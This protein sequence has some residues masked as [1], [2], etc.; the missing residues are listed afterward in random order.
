MKH[1]VEEFLPSLPK[2]ANLLE[3]G[4]GHGLLLHLANSVPN[5]GPTTAWDVSDASLELAAHTLKTFGSKKVVKFQKRNIFEPEI[6]APENA[7]L[8]DGVVLSE[9]L[10]HL[11]E[12]LRAIQVLF[13]ICKPG[14]KVWINVPA[15]SPAPDHLYLVN[16]LADAVAVVKE[17]GFEIAAEVAY[18]MSG[19]TL[20]RAKK[21]KLTV[22]CI[23]VGRKPA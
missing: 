12:P 2:G 7:G 8:F 23:V 9:V 1:Y 14:G 19:V 21:Q 17:A 11:E 15:N 10:E 20:E 3:I 22:S 5:I 6:M 18:P 4:P 13:H 16:E